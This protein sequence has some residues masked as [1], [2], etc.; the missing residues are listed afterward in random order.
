LKA[1]IQEYIVNHFT[2]TELHELTIRKLMKHLVE[3][4]KQGES[5]EYIDL[6]KEILKKKK[7]LLKKK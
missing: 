1:K 3:I 7:R 2:E 6:V 4:K 5:K